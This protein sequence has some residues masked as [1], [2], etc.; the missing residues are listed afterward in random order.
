MA[1]SSEDEGREG[2]TYSLASAANSLNKKYDEA[3]GHNRNAEYDKCIA[4]CEEL[5]PVAF[6]TNN[7]ILQAKFNTLAGKA[8]YAKEMKNAAKVK[9]QASLDVLSRNNVQDKV[10]LLDNYLYLRQFASSDA[11][12]TKAIQ[13]KID[14]LTNAT[15]KMQTSSKSNEAKAKSLL[16]MEEEMQ[17]Y[18]KEYAEVEKKTAATIAAMSEEQ[19][20]DKLTISLKDEALNRLNYADSLSKERV[21]S[22]KLEIEQAKAVRNFYAV[23]FAFVILLLGGSVYLFLKSK[24]TAKIMEEK[25]KLIEIERK[26][27]DDLLLNIF[28][29]S[30]AQELK[31]NNSAKARHFEHACVGFLDFVSFSKISEQYSPQIVLNDLN[32]CFKAFD[33]ILTK[34]GLEKIKTIGDCYMFAGG[35][36]ESDDG[37]QIH[38]MVKASR[39]MV[40][41]LAKWNVDRAKDKLSLYE[42]RVGIHSGPV[43]A[44]VVGSRRFLYDIWGDTVNIASR[45]E[46]NSEKG[47]IN[48]SET[49]YN[50]LDGLEKCK[51]RG[52]IEAKNK[53]LL[54]MYFIEY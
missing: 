16:Q 30:I 43:A 49:V 32:F 12:A 1:W 4:I 26:K 45:M 38:K 35:L 17:K 3:Y 20:R 44:G 52:E 39:E 50:G 23:G 40:D 24:K 27:S 10:L 6:K 29:A 54:K 34:Y 28:P 41:W 15:P 14:Q 33:D 36:E 7:F 9:F 51:Y 19:V 5:I 25:N 8:Y 48:V 11:E 22:Q 37:Q 42:S 53:G 18:R 47:R 21:S 31:D 46:S 13:A 2:N